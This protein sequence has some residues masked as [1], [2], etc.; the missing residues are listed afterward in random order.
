M[1]ARERKWAPSAPTY[2]VVERRNRGLCI[3]NRPHSSERIV[4]VRYREPEEREH[5]IPE[6]T[7]DA[8]AV[9]LNHLGRDPPMGADC[10]RSSSMSG[11][12]PGATSITATVTR[13]AVAPGM[14]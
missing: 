1:P 11:C 12:T 4:L 6:L 10:G 3:G 9:P 5:G 2:E 8:A 14:P 13:R 7:L